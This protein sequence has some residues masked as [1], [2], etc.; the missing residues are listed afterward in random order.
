MY[1]Q[2]ILTSKK[3]IDDEEIPDLLFRDISLEEISIKKRISLLKRVHEILGN[4][5]STPAIEYFVMINDFYFSDYDFKYIFTNISISIA[6]MILRQAFFFGLLL[7]DI[8]VSQIGL[9]DLSS[10]LTFWRMWWRVF[11]KTRIN[12]LWLRFWFWWLCCSSL[13]LG[14]STL[15]KISLWVILMEVSWL[16]RLWLDAFCI[17]W[18]W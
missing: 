1:H 13:K 17:F 18:P 6:A 7:F 2:K 10:I 5:Y 14:L 15:W 12:S 16:A 9:I 11:R 8:V 3:K 4:D